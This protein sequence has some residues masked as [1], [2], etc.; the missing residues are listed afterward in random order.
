MT[1]AHSI[2]GVDEQEGCMHS[3][4]Q[5]T[6]AHT[7]L[8]DLPPWGYAAIGLC[9]SALN[10]G[11]AFGILYSRGMLDQLFTLPKTHGS[12]LA[13]AHVAEEFVVLP[14]IWAFYGWMR[15]AP[16]SVLRDLDRRGVLDRGSEDGEYLGFTTGAWSI[17]YLAGVVFALLGAR[18]ML[19]NPPGWNQ[20]SRLFA[21]LIVPM[22]FVLW[23]M[24]WGILWTIV[25]AVVV[26]GKTFGR[27]ALSF[28]PF[29]P[30]RVGGLGP[31]KRYA[32]TL[33]SFLAVV[34]AG[35]LIDTAQGLLTGTFARD[36]ILQIY[37]V[38]Y[39]I[40]VPVCFLASLWPAHAAM[41]RERDKI[42]LSSIPS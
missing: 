10:D 34:G 14:A 15:R 39:A 21:Q 32:Q 37:L 19:M 31:L 7:G 11:I 42:L 5:A 26:F 2:P 35:L 38:S 8:G 18:V 3:G 6:P 27:R 23:L 33:V 28:R 13:A 17:I 41:T 25:D 30:D 1:L 4:E 16:Q 12:L 20:S 40:L 9:A 22:T 24:V 36:A 29:H